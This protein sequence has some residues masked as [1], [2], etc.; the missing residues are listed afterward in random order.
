VIFVLDK[1]KFTRMINNKIDKNLY[2]A[3]A[4]LGEIIV[5]NYFRTISLYNVDKLFDSNSKND[6]DNANNIV[7][8]VLYAFHSM[9]HSIQ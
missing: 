2:N 8:N 4:F 9:K 3:E 5:T 7:K 1:G 6:I